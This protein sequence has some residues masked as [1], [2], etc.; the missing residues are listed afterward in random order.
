MATNHLKT[1]SEILGS[2]LLETVRRLRGVLLA[3]ARDVR[4]ARRRFQRHYHTI[5]ADTLYQRRKTNAG[6]VIG[7]NDND[8]VRRTH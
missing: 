1:G 3:G 2:L 6:T 7:K 8:G 5:A 4:Q